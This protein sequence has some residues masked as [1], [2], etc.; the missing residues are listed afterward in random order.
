MK[1]LI[2]FFLLT[3][4]TATKERKSPEKETIYV[5]YESDCSKTY[6]TLKSGWDNDESILCCLY[7]KGLIELLRV[8]TNCFNGFTRENVKDYFGK[9]AGDTEVSM[10]YMV[11]SDCS[12]SDLGNLLY[13]VTFYFLCEGQTT[14]KVTSCAIAK[15]N[16]AV[17]DD[18]K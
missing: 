11:Y 10:I 14:S 17:F 6:S 15:S 8:N 2:F 5:T 12:S 4:C 18:R 7:N 13:Y 9:P 1:Y 16:I 3:A